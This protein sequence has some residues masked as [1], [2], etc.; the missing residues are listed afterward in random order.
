M[1]FHTRI[2]SVFKYQHIIFDIIYISYF[3]NSI[4]AFIKILVIRE[5]EMVQTMLET[6]LGSSI[7]K[8]IKYV[9]VYNY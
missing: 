6:I 8:I 1:S 7:I 4:M 9:V 5:I 2:D 3:R